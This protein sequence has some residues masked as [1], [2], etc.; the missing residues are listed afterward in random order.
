M[1][2]QGQRLNLK[3]TVADVDFVVGLARS[4]RT[5][6]EIVDRLKVK[7]IVAAPGEIVRLC[8]EARQKV[9]YGQQQAARP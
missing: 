5:A 2:P 4:G 1:N 3:W 8:F 6:I 9:N 7:G